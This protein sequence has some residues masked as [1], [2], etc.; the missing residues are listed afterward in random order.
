LETNERK[1]SSIL[2]DSSGGK[3]VEIKGGQPGL[4]RGGGRVFTKKGQRHKRP[5]SARLYSH[6]KGGGRTFLTYRAM[7]ISWGNIPPVI[8]ACE[9]IPRG[10]APKAD[11]QNKTPRVFSNGG[12]T[13]K[14][15]IR[16]LVRTQWALGGD[17]SGT[18]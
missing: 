16:R 10:G 14:S 11:A 9:S 2:P 15:P 7:A 8:M 13:S 17:P 4:R 1:E 6:S 18:L 3:K 5:N 12:C